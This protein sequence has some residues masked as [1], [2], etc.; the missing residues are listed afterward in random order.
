MPNMIKN[1]NPDPGQT[2]YARQG[3]ILV[4]SFRDQNRRKQV[5]LASTF[6][7]A[8]QAINAKPLIVNAYNFMGGVDLSDQMMAFYNDHRKQIK[9]WKKIYYTCFTEYCLILIS[10]I[11]STHLITQYYQDLNS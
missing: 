5:K 3:N 11:I 8:I 6:Y 7:S 4:Y 9:V 2:T 1:A 10:C